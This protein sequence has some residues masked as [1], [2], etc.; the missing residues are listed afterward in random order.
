MEERVDIIL[1]KHGRRPRQPWELIT[2][3]QEVQEAEGYLKPAALKHVSR[4]MGIPL[5]QV[6]GVATFFRSLSVT[7]QGRRRVT[8]CMG[9]ACHV[10]GAPR[11]LDE[12]SDL[13]GVSPGGTTEDG[14][15]TLD[16][17]NCLGTCAIGPVMMLDGKY[18]GKISAAKAKKLLAKKRGS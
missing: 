5:P 17:V 16:A 11:L 18:H 13:L 4:M 15:F 1:K 10:R 7:P 6:Y 14:E 2:I 8:I 12:V 3:L 9:T